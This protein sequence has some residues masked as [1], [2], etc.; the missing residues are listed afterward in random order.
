MKQS[1]DLLAS[2]SRF[3]IAAAIVYFAYQLA[4][5]NNIPAVLQSVD[6]ISQQIDPALNEVAAIR[7]EIAEVRKQIPPILVQVESINQQI[8]PILLRVDKT[9]AVVDDTQQQIPQI[10]TT[11][12]NAIAALNDTRAEVIP[13]VPEALEQVKLTR[14]SVDPTL[15]RVEVLVDDAYSKALNAIGA[16]KT[17][18]QEASEGAV[19]GFFTGL[20]KLPFKLVGTLASPL[21]KN[22]DAE[23]AEQLVES[24]LELMVEAGER[25]IKS[26]KIGQEQRWKNP[27]S[28]NSGSLTLVRTFEL[29]GFECNEVRIRI[30]NA[31]QQEI[32]DKIDEFCLN[33]EDKWVLAT[34]LG[35]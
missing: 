12:D 8:E 6:Q 11:T 19:T 3:A 9:V 5:I 20:V 14:E 15:D 34:E 13:L 29:E 2:A 21:T 22:M 32:Q 30:S 16:A 17:A 25:G 23:V 24:D 33:Q 7:V 18:G 28:G 26:G 10:L 27:E 1:L 4:Q 31:R 35:K